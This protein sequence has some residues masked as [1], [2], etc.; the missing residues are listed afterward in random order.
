[1][2]DLRQADEVDPHRAKR[3]QCRVA[4]LR[5]RGVR[6]RCQLSDGALGHGVQRR[7]LTE[8]ITFSHNDSNCADEA[9]S[10]L[11][12]TGTTFPHGVSINPST[13]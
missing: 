10:E 8:V 11:Q 3:S 12:L 2:P 1:M 6:Q 4:H 5:M 7:K 13:P 9:W